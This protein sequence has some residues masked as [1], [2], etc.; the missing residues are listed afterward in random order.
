MD[1]LLRPFLA[2][3]QGLFWVQSLGSFKLLLR[4]DAPTDSV[5]MAV[6]LWV[7]STNGCLRHKYVKLL[8]LAAKLA[9]VRHAI[10]NVPL[11]MEN[12]PS[13]SCLI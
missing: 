4:R 7:Y 13:F 1:S 6:V 5:D 9:F 12:I 11:D 2:A 8:G 10:L 3:P